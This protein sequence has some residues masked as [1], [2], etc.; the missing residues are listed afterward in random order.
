MVGLG[1]FGPERAFLPGFELQ[2]LHVPGHPVTAARDAFPLQ[3]DGQA[4]TAIH[5]AVGA[6]QTRQ[7]GAQDLVLHR[8]PAGRPVAPRI[9]GTAGHP[10]HLAEIG[11]GIFLGHLCN[12]G[13]PLGGTSESMPKA[14]F[15]IS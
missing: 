11:D 4:W 12:Q 8:A 3:A 5:F 2:G 14:F 15:R 6:K 1:G 7:F 10:Q 13:I 9:V